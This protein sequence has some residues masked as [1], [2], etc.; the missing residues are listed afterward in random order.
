MCSPSLSKHDFFFFF[1]LFICDVAPYFLQK[2]VSE[3]F[4]F[5]VTLLQHHQS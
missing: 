3:N 1:I 2:G 5:H 4:D